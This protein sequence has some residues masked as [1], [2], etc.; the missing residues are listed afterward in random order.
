MD[1]LVE[2]KYLKNNSIDF[3]RLRNLVQHAMLGRAFL[4]IQG[5]SKK[6]INGFRNGKHVSFLYNNWVDDS[7]PINK[8]LLNMEEFMNSRAKVCDFITTLKKAVSF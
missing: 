6:I 7:Q 3:F 5:Y 2:A 4:V 8:I 1:K